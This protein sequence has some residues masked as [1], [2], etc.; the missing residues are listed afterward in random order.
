MPYR[1]V[2]K[3]RRPTFKRT[4]RKGRKLNVRQKREVKRIVGHTEEVKYH[5]AGQGATGVNNSGTILNLFTPAQGVA[6]INA[7]TGDIVHLKGMR[8]QFQAI[9]GDIYNTMRVVVFRWKSPSGT[10]PT[11]ADVFDTNATG[12]EYVMCPCPAQGAQQKVE[13]LYDKVVTLPQTNYYTSSSQITG[14]S[15][16]VKTWS[17]QL[18][19]KH[20][21]AKVVR[22]NPGT[23]VIPSGSLW[24]YLISDSAIPSNPTMYVNVRV[25]Y[26]NA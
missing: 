10:N 7:R 18:F 1:R 14:T 16:S 9:G 22:F 20:L 12:A 8:L 6:G 17:K 4:V 21:G 24:M 13:V 25:A 11:L 26:V 19:G 3:G 2:Y 15:A 5:Y 23:T